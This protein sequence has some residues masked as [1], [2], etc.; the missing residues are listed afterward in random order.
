MLILSIVAGAL[1]LFFLINLAVKE[2]SKTQQV[3][4]KKLEA[5]CESNCEDNPITSWDELLEKMER[6]NS[7]C[8]YGSEASYK[9]LKL[10][11]IHVSSRHVFTTPSELSM[12]TKS[13]GMLSYEKYSTFMCEGDIREFIDTHYEQ[14][15]TLVDKVVAF[16]NDFIKDAVVYK[17]ASIKLKEFY[18]QNGIKFKTWND[19]D[20]WYSIND[21]EYYTTYHRYLYR[22]SDWSKMDTDEAY[23]IVK[24]AKIELSE[25]PMKVHWEHFLKLEMLEKKAREKRMQEF[26]DSVLSKQVKYNDLQLQFEMLPTAP[27]TDIETFKNFCKIVKEDV[28]YEDHEIQNYIFMKKLK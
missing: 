9:G 3:K 26:V 15:D 5:N 11:M 8:S 13:G 14:Y 6:F 22:L 25:D 2:D 21:G 18:E 7:V 1:F 16:L 20:V 10:D 28:Y 19:E 23:E 17:G 27:I 12:R 4:E 24:N